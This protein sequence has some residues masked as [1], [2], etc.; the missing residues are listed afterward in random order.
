M[1]NL[2]KKEKTKITS[3]KLLSLG[4]IKND[5]DYCFYYDDYFW[6]SYDIDFQIICIDYI[7]SYDDSKKY[8]V[9]PNNTI[10]YVEDLQSLCFLLTGKKLK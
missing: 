6:I 8:I 5:T 2:F 4:F 9:I 1:F 3:D 7:D 10:K